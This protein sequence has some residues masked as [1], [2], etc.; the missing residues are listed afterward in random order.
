MRAEEEEMAEF[1]EKMR[2]AR[3]VF[4]EQDIEELNKILADFLERSQAKCALLIDKE[5]HLVT[6]KGFT[7]SFNTDSIAALVA[8]SF[9]AT[10]QVAQLLGETEFSVLFHQGKNENIHIGL[11]AER[12]LVVVIFDDR[13]TLGM[14][15]LYAEE[16]QQ[17]L[18][19]TM[20]QSIERN[21]D[22]S[23]SVSKEYGQ[24]AEQ[25]LDDFFGDKK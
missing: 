1:S 15:R 11:V 22:K 21:K 10:K 24:A 23:S 16:L 2:Q 13:T 5:G 9:A 8:G 17:K 7:K 12:A 20:L 3:L 4:Y 19:D 18:T 6:K 14:V 25:A